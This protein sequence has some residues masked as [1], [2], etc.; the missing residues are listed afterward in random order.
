VRGALETFRV[1]LVDALRAG[2][3]GGEP[4]TLR[5][6]FQATYRSIIAGRTSQLGCDRVAGKDAL[7]ALGDN[8]ARLALSAV[9]AGA[10]RRV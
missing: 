8:L 7:T 3:P 2:R 5:N 9:V 4:P 6:D 1:E 10:S